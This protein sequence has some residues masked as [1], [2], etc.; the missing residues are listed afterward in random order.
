VAG[1]LQGMGCING[2]RV[3]VAPDIAAVLKINSRI[4]KKEQI[5]GILFF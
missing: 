5:S 1:C 2:G 3:G 4:W